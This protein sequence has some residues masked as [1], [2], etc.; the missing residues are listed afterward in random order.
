MPDTTSLPATA[1]EPAVTGRLTPVKIRDIVER[2]RE[3]FD[4]SLIYFKPQVVSY[5]GE[6]STAKGAAYA[7]AK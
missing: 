3:P 2:L 7:V 1:A 5:K 4:P 6:N